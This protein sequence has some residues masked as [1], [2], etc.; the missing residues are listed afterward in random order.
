MPFAFWFWLFMVL[1]FLCVGIF[2][3]RSQ[4]PGQPYYYFF[5]GHLLEFLAL[6]ILGWQVFGSPFSSLVK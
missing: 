6:V 4:I 3:Y 2:H 1:W 5:S